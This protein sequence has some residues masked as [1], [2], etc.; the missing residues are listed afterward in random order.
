MRGSVTG[1][2]TAFDNCLN[3]LKSYEL[4]FLFIQAFKRKLER[5]RVLLMQVYIAYY[6]HI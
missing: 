1:Y 6:T 5:S 4:K 3:F 2:Q